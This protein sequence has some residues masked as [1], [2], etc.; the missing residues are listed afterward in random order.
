ME[1]DCLMC[2]ADKAHIELKWEHTTRFEML[3]R[4]M[5]DAEISRLSY[6]V[7]NGEGYEYFDKNYSSIYRWL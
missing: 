3:V 6:G 5:I 7:R 4:I 2:R 1:V